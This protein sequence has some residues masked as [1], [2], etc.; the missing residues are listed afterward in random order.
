MP[1]DRTY[2]TFS[3]SQHIVT[4]P[5][6]TMLRA[7]KAHLDAQPDAQPDTQI[8]IFDNSTGRQADF[9]FRGTIE[10]VVGRYVKEEP[11]RGPGRPKLGVVAREVT[12]LPRHWE[13]L[14]EQPSGAS[15]AIRRLVDQARKSE[16]GS[17][18]A[19]TVTGRVMTS[20]AGDLPNYEEAYRA[21][22]ASDRARFEQ[23]TALWPT[24]VRS[25]LLDLA[26]E[27]FG[28]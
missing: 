8:L 10:D 1:D 18:R 11:A 9:D 19:A 26:V 3:D 5:L 22:D 17:R 23:L 7:T 6:E 15:A 27:V 21:L 12:L 4:G 25:H 13:W 24:D 16:D 28:E 14:A 20:L 2:T